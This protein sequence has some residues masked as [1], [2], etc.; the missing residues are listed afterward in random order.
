M[1]PELSESEAKAVQ[2]MMTVDHNITLK[3]VENAIK[4][5]DATLTKRF[6][7]I[8]QQQHNAAK[9]AKEAAKSKEESKEKD[10]NKGKGKKNKGKCNNC[11]K[12]CL[13]ANVEIGAEAGPSNAKPAEAGPSKPASKAGSKAGSPKV[14]AK[15][16]DTDD[17]DDTGS[18]IDMDFGSETPDG[19]YSANLNPTGDNGSRE[20]SMDE[21]RYSRR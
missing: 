15:D 2:G 6:D 16:V 14:K 9:G 7:E 8:K 13:V 10:K 17:D 5:S 3:E 12:T 18:Y 19:T 21:V 20:L 11:G 4:R 1:S